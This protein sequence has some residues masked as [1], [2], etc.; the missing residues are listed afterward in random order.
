MS[1]AIPPAYASVLQTLINFFDSGETD[2]IIRADQIGRLKVYGCNPGFA[3]PVMNWLMRN[4]IVE[5]FTVRDNVNQQSAWRFT[6]KGVEACQEF[7][8]THGEIDGSRWT[9]LELDRDEAAFRAAVTAVDE[10]SDRVRGDNEFAIREPVI[11]RSISD[12]LKSGLVL[13][14]TQVM[15]RIQM[16]AL[17]IDPATW[18]AGQFART[19]IGELA[20]HVITSLIGFM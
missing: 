16:N 15:T 19:A 14:K 18:I 13:L 1:V 20:E 2:G 7:L 8:K 11:H 5:E 3:G 10:L 12:S 9:P 6:L 17:L 4:D